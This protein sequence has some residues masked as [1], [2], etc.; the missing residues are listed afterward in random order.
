MTTP[1][2]WQA[3]IIARANQNLERMFPGKHK[4][5]TFDEVRNRVSR[6]APKL[7]SEA[8]SNTKLAKNDGQGYLSAGLPLAPASLA[9][10]DVCGG[11]SPQCRAMCLKFSGRMTF[12][13]V[14]RAQILKTLARYCFPY[15][16][17]DKLRHE[18]RNLSKLATKKG[19]KAAVRLNVLS[20]LDWRY[21]ASEFPE[22]QVYDYTKRKDLMIDFVMGKFPANY[23]L[24]FSR[25]ELTSMDAIRSIYNAGHNVTVP[26]LIKKGDKLPK[27]WKGMRVIDGD[28]SD[29]RFLDKK[30]V[31]VGLKAKGKAR[32]ATRDGFV[33][34]N[35]A[36]RNAAA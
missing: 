5:I 8:R 31:I 2:P 7:L 23:H 11:S 35:H 27:T 34:V 28:E 6:S 21:I 9:G 13:S 36:G 12:Y 3:E 30:G 18:L 22:I 16:F 10:V 24:T 29:L 32:R 20:D 1:K 17:D 26:F 33:I 15:E 19:L 4:T 25:S 14:T